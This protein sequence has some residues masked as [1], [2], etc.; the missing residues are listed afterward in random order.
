MRRHERNVSEIFGEIKPG[1]SGPSD[2]C[3]VSVYLNVF[4]LAHT[5][6]RAKVSRNI[7]DCSGQLAHSRLLRMCPCPKVQLSRKGCC[8]HSSLADMCVCP[9]LHQE[10]GIK[11][12][13]SETEQDIVTLMVSIDNQLEYSY[14]MWSFVYNYNVNEGH[15]VI[16]ISSLPRHHSNLCCF[17]VCGFPDI[18]P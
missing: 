12:F 5:V 4:R 10:N 13:A 14:C 6:G 2:G 11:T 8:Q 17:Y 7:Q 1:V 16:P 9:F 3:A 15:K 18:S